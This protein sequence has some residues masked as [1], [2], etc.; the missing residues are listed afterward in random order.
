M[1]NN[2]GQVVYSRGATKL[3]KEQFMELIKAKSPIRAGRFSSRHILETVIEIHGDDLPILAPL[4][5]EAHDLLT[6]RVSE[7]GMGFKYRRGNSAVPDSY[8]SPQYG[9]RQ[10]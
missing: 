7:G 1:T 6:D 9:W 5:K 10:P 3:N 4:L 2:N 8:A